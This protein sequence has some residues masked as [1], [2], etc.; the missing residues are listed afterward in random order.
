MCTCG[1]AWGRAE[2]ARVVG[3]ALQRPVGV[4]DRGNPQVAAVDGLIRVARLGYDRTVVYAE[5]R[6]DTAALAERVYEELEARTDWPIA[7]VD[8]T[9]DHPEDVILSERL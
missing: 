1:Q 6:S 5:V 3:A 2:V 4:D 8:S 7:L 9:D